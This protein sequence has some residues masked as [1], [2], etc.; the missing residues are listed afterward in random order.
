MFR[1]VLSPDSHD[2]GIQVEY[3]RGEA[4]R[5]PSPPH[6]PLPTGWE[7]HEGP[8]SL[9]LLLPSSSFFYFHKLSFSLACPASSQ[10]RSKPH[11]LN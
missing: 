5:E 7:R 1:A 9:S 10:P 8:L 11:F 3:S 4:P 2:S 6:R